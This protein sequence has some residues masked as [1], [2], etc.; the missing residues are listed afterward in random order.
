MCKIRGHRYGKRVAIASQG[1]LNY[2]KRQHVRYKNK[3]CIKE[4]NFIPKQNLSS[5]RKGEG[6]TNWEGFQKEF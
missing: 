6:E 3:L 5:T 1:N 2:Y 4:G